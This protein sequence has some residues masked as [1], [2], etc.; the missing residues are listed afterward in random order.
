[1]MNDTPTACLMLK[2][3]VMPSSRVR[4][5]LSFAA[6]VIVYVL[7]A[8]L[9]LRFAVVHASATPLWPPTGIALAALV[10]GGYRWWPAIF[11]G[12]FVANVTTAGSV[13]TSLGIA[14]G[15]AAEAL[16][17]AALVWRFADGRNAFALPRTIFAFVF[18]AGFL[19]P[20]VSATVGVSSL[21]LGGYAAWSGVGAIWL[22]WWLGDV[23]GALV[24]APLLIVWANEPRVAGGPARRAEALALLALTIAAGVL[25]FG[26]AVR[27]DAHDAPLAFLSLPALVWGAYRFGPR[28]ATTVLTVLSAIA[29]VGTVYGRGPFAVGGPNASLLLLQAFLIT[30]AG[31][32]LPLA[33]LAEELARR[34]ARSAENARLYRESE[35]QRRT[36]EAFAATSRALAQSLDV[37]DVAER[38]VSSARELLGGTVAIVYQLDAATGGHQALALAGDAG[39]QF[40]G[41]FTIPEGVGT[42]GLALREGRLVATDDVTSDPRIVLTPDIRARLAR[43]PHRAVL[44]VPLVARGRTIGAFMVG[45]RAGR[46]FTHAETMLAETFAHHAALAIANAHV[47]EEERAARADAESARADAEAASRAKDEFL[48]VLSH[49]LRTPLTAIVGWARMLRSG[50]LPAAAVA[51][52]VEVIDRNA[53]AQVQLIEDLLDVSRIV[54]GTLR[55][56]LRPVKLA[57]VL[58]AA[59][60]AVRP[61]AERQGV[62][63]TSNV[64]ARLDLVTADAG[65]LQQVFWNLLANAVKFTPSGGSIAVTAANDHGGVRLSVADTGAGIDATTLPHV[66][67]RF[68]QADSS[69]TRRH[70]GLGLGLALVKH[71]VELHGGTVC[72]ESDGLGRGATFTVSLPSA[73][74]AEIPEPSPSPAWPHGATLA[75][76][77]VLV[78]DD[79]PDAR[80]FCEQALAR[81][82]AAVVT[83]DSVSHALERMAAVKPDVV[84]TDLAMPGE[85][86]F[87][88]IRKL[89][90][91]ES[92]R[93]RRVVA[94]ALT[95]YAGEQDRR[96]VLDAGFDAH[97]AKPFDPADLARTIRALLPHA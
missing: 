68:R 18:G 16:T 75:D 1:M 28:G 23:A 50:N 29:A 61:T 4:R 67:E 60:D 37:K 27:T 34:E 2:R 21:V 40:S 64:A 13:A 44:A 31:T 48:A 54:S 17:G 66:F 5:W 97:M 85:D 83:A 71:I 76:V 55:L 7:A 51:N 89:R 91:G 88:L 14:A 30:T 6:L 8:K 96:R 87:G 94:V 73:G 56:E 92:D 63:I 3:D 84:V 25:V 58:G 93:G 11:L 80:E 65:R 43:T 41:A 53:A 81:H 49:E 95:A 62:A 86:G 57:P 9:G 90:A 22:T 10:L 47:F 33:A 45:D 78:V 42:I 19:A 46:A 15:N 79:E 32:I 39:P 59:V 38:V 82:G 69:M 36:A 35:G 70:G 52:A 74:A 72:A 20:V 12:A 24:L 77:T 26:G